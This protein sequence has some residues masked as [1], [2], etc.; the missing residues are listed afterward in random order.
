MVVLKKNKI[1]LGVVA[2]LASSFV[3]TASAEDPERLLVTTAS[4]FKQTVE[5][6]PASVSVVTR[7][8]LETKSYRD[9]TDALKDV[10]GVLVT[11]GGS[12]SDISIRG[13]DPKYT[14]I[15]VDGKRV[16]S[17]ETRPNSDNS[18]IE[19]GW[20]PPLPAIER[21]EVVRGPMSSLYGSDAMGGVINIITRK[22]QK[23]WN[24]SLRGDTTLTERKNE[25]NTGQG[26][27]YAAG[28]LIDNVLGLKLQGQYS[29][30]GE[31]RRVDGY[32][33]QIT[34][35][36]GGTLSWTPDEKNT[37][38]FE[39]K[40]DNQHR[41]SRVGYSKSAELVKGKA[42]QSSFTDYEL[43]HYALTHDGVY[44]FGTMNTYV[45]RDESRNP[46]RKMDY[47]D[48]TVR[49]QTVFMFGD[50]MLSV[51]GQYRYEELKDEGNKL[52]G[53]NKLD[54]Y[55]WALFAEDEWTLTNDFAL[56]AG[57]RMDKDENFGTHWTPRVYGVWHLADEWTLK[58][59]VSTGYRSPDLRQAT[60]TWG[61]VTGGGRLDGVIFGNPDLKP[62]KSV[63][64]EIG[65]IWDNRDNLT[66]SLTIYN[67]D[68]KDKIMEKR[69]CDKD[70]S[71][72][73]TADNGFGH[74]YDFV[75]KRE[76]VD[77]ANMRGV[78]VTA[79][80]IISPEWNLAANYT[81]TDTEQKSGDFKGKPLN[82]QPRH[83]ANA[84]LNWETTPEMETWAR[85]NFR[86]KT[87]DYLSRTSMAKSTP[88]YAFVDVG[89]SYS[90]T[91]Q[92]NLIGGVYN[93][94][95]RRIERDNYGSTLEGR[96]YNIG[97]NY[98]F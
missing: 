92:L 10:P 96:R 74:V 86:G 66:A 71:K 65:I 64:E 2:A 31:D 3:M 24:F 93:V 52:K 1:A 14:M 45:Q 42:P 56:T 90:L 58:G 37:V 59:G 51:G 9:V 79:N 67:T 95:D 75:S 15:L 30:R 78:E 50:H 12:S 48:T 18:G 70:S 62:E 33:R 49:N 16:A 17:R 29:H 7:E 69:V 4:G 41:D 77:K 85:I 82:K 23:E 25:G 84:T 63:T 20:L 47:D 87:S 5:D 8:Q 80:W 97:L 55:S 28:P 35:S 22:A 19:Q 44:D 89:T 38:E 60:A 73:C 26:S 53:N 36:G 68:F 94:F 43:T 21:I 13:M 76:N 40:K 81:F 6:A 83:M 57:L 27:F 72:P 46:S 88:S 39:F 32:N 34:A 98:N 61:Q 11:G 54:R 91:K